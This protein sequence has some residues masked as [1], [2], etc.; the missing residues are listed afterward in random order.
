MS[1]TRKA[2]RMLK[3]RL[4]TIDLSR[5]DVKQHAPGYHGGWTVRGW[6][7]STVAQVRENELVAAIA[8]LLHDEE[9]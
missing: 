8:A 9:T 2:G 4:G 5:P 1:W 6:V 3:A 7:E